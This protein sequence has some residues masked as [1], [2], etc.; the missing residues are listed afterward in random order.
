[1]WTAA[2][3]ARLRRLRAEGAGWPAIAA[4]LDVSADMARERGRRIGARPP[5]TAPAAPAEDPGRPPL[6]PGDP[7]AWALL[8]QGTVL[9]GIDWPG[10]GA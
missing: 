1:M 2:L 8:T 6:P 4:A 9:A 3:D 10:W 5:Q 7:R